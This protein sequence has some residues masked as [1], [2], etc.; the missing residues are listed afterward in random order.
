LINANLK[1]LY[2]EQQPKKAKNEE[3]KRRIQKK[4]AKEI[5][6]FIIDMSTPNYW[7]KEEEEEDIEEEITATSAEESTL[8]TSGKSTRVKEEAYK[9]EKQFASKK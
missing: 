9:A 4:K 2:E 5:P 7:D 6:K 8:K 3:G 1:L